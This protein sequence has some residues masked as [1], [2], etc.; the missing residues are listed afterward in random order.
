[1]ARIIPKPTGGAITSIGDIGDVQ[2]TGVDDN[3]FLQYDSTSGIWINVGVA[4]GG[5]VTDHGFLTGLGDDDHPQYHNNAR[6]DARYY[7]QAQ[8]N[9]GQLDSRY[10]TETELNNGALDGRYYTETEIDNNF[11]TQTQLNNGQLDNR[12]YTEAEIDAMVQYLDAT[13][14]IQTQLD[15]KM[16]GQVSNDGIAYVY[17]N[18]RSIWLSA[19][20]IYPEW[21][22]DGNADGVLLRSAAGGVRD[23]ATGWLT[24]RNGMILGYSLRI[25]GGNNTKQFGIYIN[26]ALSTT[27]TMPGANSYIV[28]NL[29]IS[30][31][32]GDYLGIYC[33]STGLAAQNPSMYLEIAWRL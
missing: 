6:G 13:S 22:L 1:M 3:H 25:S 29:S 31:S 2:I 11:Y 24:M 10:Y 7:T 26:G 14:S 12:Y 5:G 27:I 30:L 20:R 9:G 33:S 16:D 28:T 17:D 32:A 15:A 18:S 23:A 21:G 4:P 8:L 19:T